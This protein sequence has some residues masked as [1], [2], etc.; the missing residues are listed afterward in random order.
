MRR[1]FLCGDDPLTGKNYD[2]R[3]QWIRNRLEFLA[4][5]FGVE[6]LSF[7]VLFPATSKNGW[8]RSD[9]DKATRRD[10]SAQGI[11]GFLHFPAPVLTAVLPRFGQLRN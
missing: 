9:S 5:V 10:S 3:R 6:V 8:P 7:A 11:K 4:R 1:G 2:H